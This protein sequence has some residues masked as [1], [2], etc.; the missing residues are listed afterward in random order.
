MTLRIYALLALVCLAVTGSGI[1][2]QPQRAALAAAPAATLV[3]SPGPAA[4]TTVVPLPGG[5]GGVSPGGERLAACCVSG[6][7]YMDGL[8]V[9]GAEIQ[10]SNARG[11][12]AVQ[13]THIYSGTEARPYYRVSLSVAPLAVTPGET[14]T[15]TARYSGHTRSITQ[16]V[17]LGGQQVDVVLA[18]DRAD[19]Y[20]YERQIWDQAAAGGLNVPHGVA[21]DSTGRLFVADTD[22]ARIQVFGQAGQFSHRWG[23]LGNQ[24]GQFNQPGGITADTSGDIYVADTNNHRIQKFSSQGTWIMSWG[25][26]GT[27]DG[28]FDLPWA[29]PLM[30]AT[31]CTSP[32]HRMTACKNSAA[33]ASS[34]ATGAAAASTMGSS[35]SPLVLRS[36]LTTMFM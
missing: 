18:R 7:V 34:W 5:C 30:P 16:T 2:R 22:N 3:S 14:I 35:I 11:D 17:L 36:M 24:P 12:R 15:I 4:D 23:T 32:I 21:L 10:I 27:A 19:D 6:F 28:Q 26:L 9:A 29:S 13:F 20:S 33:P 8:P 25:S 1:P 31:T